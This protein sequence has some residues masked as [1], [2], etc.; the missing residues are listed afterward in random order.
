[1]CWS[2]VAVW[3]L[4]VFFWRENNSYR[5]FKIWHVA[6]PQVMGSWMLTIGGMKIEK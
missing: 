5:A 3:L 1:M 6:V 2:S 4:N